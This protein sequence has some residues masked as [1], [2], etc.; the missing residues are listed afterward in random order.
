MLVLLATA[1]NTLFFYVLLHKINSLFNHFCARYPKGISTALQFIRCFFRQTQSEVHTFG[2]FLA[3]PACSRRHFL[4][5]LFAPAINIAVL[6]QK[7]KKNLQ[8]NACFYRRGIN[9]ASVGRDDPGAPFPEGARSPWTAGRGRPA[10]QGTPVPPAGDKAP[11]PRE[12]SAA[13]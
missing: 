8:K 10:L 3:G 9:F 7:V 4:T 5:S 6:G 13:G 1:A 11:S 12:L 2:Y